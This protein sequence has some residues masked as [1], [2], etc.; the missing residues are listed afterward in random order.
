MKNY[1]YL[2][3]FDGKNRTTSRV[4][5]MAHAH[6]K[7]KLL[8]DLVD[9]SPPFRCPAPDCSYE[10][11]ERDKWSRHYGSVHGWIKKYLKQY[12]EENPEKVHSSSANDKSSAVSSP[13]AFLS[14]PSTSMDESLLMT[15]NNG[16]QESPPLKVTGICSEQKV[17]EKYILKVIKTLINMYQ[18]AFI[19]G[20]Y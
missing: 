2:Q 4:A 9:K 15:A 8:N 3:H 13:N 6:F 10:T 14:P 20:I 1:V 7:D 11:R 12:F 5:H 17:K 16:H 18:Q 19:E